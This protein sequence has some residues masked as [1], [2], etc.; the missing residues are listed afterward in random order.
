LVVVADGRHRLDGPT[1]SP[2]PDANAAR[3]AD[4]Q[5]SALLD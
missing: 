2:S 3:V 1:Q 4:N 5:G